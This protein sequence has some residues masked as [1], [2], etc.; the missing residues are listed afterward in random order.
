VTLRNPLLFL[1][2]LPEENSNGNCGDS[3]NDDSNTNTN[4]YSSTLG[5]PSSRGCCAV[6]II[7]LFPICSSSLARFTTGRF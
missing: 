1:L 4:P 3:N 5:Q 6:V 7:F 2:T